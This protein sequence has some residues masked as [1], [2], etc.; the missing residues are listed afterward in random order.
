MIIPVRCFTCHKVLGDKWEYY[1]KKVD[2]HTD[3]K[4]KKQHELKDLDISDKKDVYFSDDF[5]GKIMDELKITKI[6]CRRHML[7]HVDLINYI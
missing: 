4:I 2:E 3:K 7:G 6:C 5:K 1:A